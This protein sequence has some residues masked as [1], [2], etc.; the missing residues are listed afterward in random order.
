[1]S[2]LAM[3]FIDKRIENEPT[4]RGKAWVVLAIHDEIIIEAPADQQDLAVRVVEEEMERAAKVFVKNI[5]FK[6]SADVMTEW[7]KGD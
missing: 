2:K 5:S 4:L 1:M 6:V 3:I 7:Q